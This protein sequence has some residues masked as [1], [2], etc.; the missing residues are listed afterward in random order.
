MARCKV[1][2][3]DSGD[4]MITDSV[5]SAISGDPVRGAAGTGLLSTVGATV[6]AAKDAVPGKSNNKA[7]ITSTHRNRIA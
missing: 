2:R 1:G 5:Q 7:D 6:G 4:G 3:G